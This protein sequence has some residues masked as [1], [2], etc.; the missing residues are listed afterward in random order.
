MRTLGRL[1]IALCAP[2]TLFAQGVFFHTFL[3]TMP[4][5]LSVIVLAAH[6]VAL[7]GFAS[8]VDSRRPPLRL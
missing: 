6:A 8:L 1:L 5:W 7:L 2:V 4:W 3:T